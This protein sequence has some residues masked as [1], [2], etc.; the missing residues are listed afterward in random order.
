MPGWA[1]LF[2]RGCSVHARICTH[3]CTHAHTHTC[4]CALWTQPRSRG[5]SLNAIRGHLPTWNTVRPAASCLLLVQKA[6]L[7][8]KMFLHVSS[9]PC[10]FLA[11]LGEKYSPNIGH[12]LGDKITGRLSLKC[13]IPS[14]IN[15]V[16]Q[17]RNEL[18]SFIWKASHL[19]PNSLPTPTHPNWDHT[20]FALS[21]GEA[22][23][24]G[25]QARLSGA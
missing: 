1:I 21:R 15:A 14:M 13:L 24:A 11:S 20:A 12:Y 18:I 10:L 7:R 3:V 2:V 4:V 22:V 9:P 25:A 6:A 16:L 5:L 17:E 19:G 8:Q 23:K